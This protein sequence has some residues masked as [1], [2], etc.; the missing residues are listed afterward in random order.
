MKDLLINKTG[1]LT[2]NYDTSISF[3]D[4]MP[5]QRG[6]HNVLSKS[7][8]GF[9]RTF[10]IKSECV[11]RDDVRTA[12][13]IFSD[14]VDYVEF[15]GHT[16]SK[17]GVAASPTGFDFQYDT[18]FFGAT[19][20]NSS[21]K[22]WRY[23]QVKAVSIISY[24]DGD[25]DL[26][27]SWQFEYV[28]TNGLNLLNNEEVAGPGSVSITD[29][30]DIALEEYNP[31]DGSENVSRIR[32]S[33]GVYSCMSIYCFIPSRSYISKV[34]ANVLGGGEHPELSRYPTITFP[35]FPQTHCVATDLQATSMESS[36]ERYSLSLK[37]EEIDVNS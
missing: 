14:N 32:T 33:A 34:A 17:R 23:P 29:K 26:R 1:F 35:G 36:T 28:D 21:I 20:E 4:Q 3:Q 13:G 19:G 8:C 5:S 30:N 37:L 11:S 31:E 7:R 25:P 12:V 16:F 6:R 10:S 24:V 2:S 9:K 15:D 22:S 18:G 27:S